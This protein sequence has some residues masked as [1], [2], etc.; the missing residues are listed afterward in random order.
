MTTQP[1]DI[2]FSH[3]RA[4]LLGTSR[5]SAGFGSSDMPAAANSLAAM[6]GALVK[7]CGWPGSRIS[8][9]ADRSIRDL[10][11]DEIAHL[12]HEA[13][14]VLLLYYVGHGQLLLGNDL[15]LALTDTSDDPRLRLSTSLRLSQ[16]RQE[17]EYNCDAR[18]KI[19]ILD[20]CCAG[21]ATKYSQ[22][23]PADL[24]KK[25]S[26]AAEVEGEG[27]YIWTACGHSQDAYF[28]PGP[29]GMTYFTKFL[30][31]TI[32]KGIKD[33][34]H[35]GL[36]MSELHKQV[37]QLYRRADITGVLVK[38]EPTLLFHGT[39]DAFVFAPNTA[40]G[41]TGAG[42]APAN[43]G[44]K[45]AARRAGLLDEAE[46]AARTIGALEC[47]ADVL[48]KIAEE[49]LP[50][51]PDRSKRLLNEGERYARQIDTDSRVRN[52]AL[53]QVARVM[54]GILPKHSQQLFEEAE[55]HAEGKRAAFQ[56]QMQ[57]HIAVASAAVD[58]GRS[59]RL[60]LESE[61]AAP[62]N[63][64]FSVA[65]WA[66]IDPDYAETV[67]RSLDYQAYVP[68]E[69]GQPPDRAEAQVRIAATL[70]Y[71]D[72]RRSYRLLAETE[73]AVQRTYPFQQA[74]ILIRIA[75]IWAAI[76]PGRSSRTLDEAEACARRIAEKT[77]ATGRRRI[78]F[79]QAWMFRQI[80]FAS[81]HVDLD[82]SNR[83]LSEAE[84]L[85]PLN[86]KNMK[87]HDQILYQVAV[88]LAARDPAAAGDLASR[89][90]IGWWQDS[91]MRKVAI[92]LAADN[93]ERAEEIARKI[94][95]PQFHASALFHV[96][97]GRREGPQV[98]YGVG[99]VPYY[100]DAW[101]Y[102]ISDM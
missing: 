1:F 59:R 68:D 92:V 43:G 28:E 63:R 88:A 19:L 53:L 98:A 18:R 90:R 54:A 31:D 13:Q 74:R 44:P 30:T 8:E 97:S 46:L 47:R 32:V 91:V 94:G 101:E 93:P 48:P 20:C 80:A 55:Q 75:R 67:A 57:N 50:S 25:V 12:I 41:E 58:P 16:I 7:P 72:A 65:A 23:S 27:V 40:I 87:E 78:A 29:G 2:D 81:A 77:E 99:P 86:K 3:S 71:G 76:D 95:T 66:V 39:D 52:W 83:L 22:S 42:P 79:S 89:L 56:A 15:G 5:Y 10:A 100:Y 21:M 60:L 51:D 82:R 49:L 70:V 24:G 17:I 34:P 84:R 45:L 102:N 9:V 14:D 37:K 62:W 61:A 96:A 6:R 4:I 73:Q 35:R 26:Q 11:L 38:P 69:P 33:G 36:T 64:E 85:S